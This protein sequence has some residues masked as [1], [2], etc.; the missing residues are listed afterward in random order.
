MHG[1][2]TRLLKFSSDE[3]SL[4]C[5][6]RLIT[7]TGKD[8]DREL[9]KVDLMESE[10]IVGLKGVHYFWQYDYVTLLLKKFFFFPCRCVLVPILSASMTS[11]RKATFPPES[12][13]C[14]KM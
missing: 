3:E 11:S 12:A 13:L 7:T 1:C 6:A 5:F 10:R 2:I 4:E 8:L 9:A 14:Y